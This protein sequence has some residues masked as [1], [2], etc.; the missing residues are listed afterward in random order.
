MRRSFLAILGVC[1][2][3]SVSSLPAY[4]EDASGP[5]VQSE[6]KVVAEMKSPK[7]L[8]LLRCSGC[9]N[10]NGSGSLG[11]GVPQLEGYLGPMA[12]DYEGRVYIAHV[13]GVVS[14]RLNDKQ[15]VD[16]LNYLI[17]EWGEDPQ[18]DRP[19]HF[20][21]E[22]LQTLKSVPVNNIVEYRR[23]VVARLAEQ[24]HPI[25]EYPWP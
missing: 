7:S 17:D 22:E 14:A 10:A 2:G 15:L 18:G 25:A 1:V 8:F 11:G 3:L 12:N 20:T 9:H 23:A 21:V 6:N 16:V 5:Y 13:P 24:G 19:P 4:A